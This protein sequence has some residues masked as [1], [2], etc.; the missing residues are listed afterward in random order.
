MS[1]YSSLSDFSNTESGNCVPALGKER[2]G[3]PEDLEK[4]I[5]KLGA[6]E[7]ELKSTL[8]EKNKFKVENQCNLYPSV[9]V[10]VRHMSC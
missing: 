7:V 10:Q 1:I 6:V 8:I 5:H 3:L 4:L 9:K 2:D